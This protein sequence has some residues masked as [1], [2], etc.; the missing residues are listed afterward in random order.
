MNLMHQPERAG[1]EQEPASQL[2][3]VTPGLLVGE[4]AEVSEFENMNRDME[5]TD[6]MDARLD[7]MRPTDHVADPV[8]RLTITG[9]VL[10]ATRTGNDVVDG[11]IE[12]MMRAGDPMRD[13]PTAQM[14]DRMLFVVTD[15]HGLDALAAFRSR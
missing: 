6:R 7:V 15:S 4:S 14:A 11:A 3:G 2:P 8:S 13:D 1:P 10:A 9:R 5:L 12:R